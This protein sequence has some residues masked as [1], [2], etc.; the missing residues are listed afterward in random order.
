MGEYDAYGAPIQETVYLGDTP[1]AVLQGASL[2]FL[3]SDHLNTSRVI[4]DQANKV[5]WN[6]ASDPFGATAANEDPDGDGVK[7]TYNLRFPGQ[8]YDRETGLHYNYFRDYDPRIGRFVESDPIGLKGG[9][10]LYVYSL[11]NPIN[12]FDIDGREPATTSD[13]WTCVA[14][15]FDCNQAMNC[16][17]KALQATISKFGHQGHNNEADAFRHCY[18]SCCMAQKIGASEAKKFGDSHEESPN[19]PKCEKEMDLYNNNIGRNL[20]ASNPKGD[21]GALCDGA[22]LQKK[23]K[24]CCGK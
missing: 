21:C 11:N 15:P 4:T 16:R 20:G 24:D 1:V 9:V 10:N 18:W 6:W 13:M 2:Y 12:R 5:I 7:F 19:Q 22:P 3:Y 14:N 8:Y 17:D 23:P